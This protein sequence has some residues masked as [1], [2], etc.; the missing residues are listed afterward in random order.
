MLTKYPGYFSKHE[1]GRPVGMPEY[2]GEIYVS[3]VHTG[4]KYSFFP[5]TSINAKRV[6]L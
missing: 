5:S 4:T 1:T 2:A 3:K 6:L